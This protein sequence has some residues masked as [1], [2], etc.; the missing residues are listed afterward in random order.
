VQCGFGRVGSHFWGFELQGVTPDIVVMG[1]PIGN[2]HP[3]A[4]VVTTRDL[5]RRFANGMEYFN[6]FGGNP[7]SMAVGHAVLDVIER[8]GLQARALETG[9]LLLERFSDM[10]GRFPI[11]GDVR[12]AGLFTGV[13]LVRDR[14]TLEPATEEAGL[15]INHMRQLGVLASTDGP[16]DNVLKFKPPMVFGKAEADRLC[17]AV[18]TSLAALSSGRLK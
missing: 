10:Q 17:A 7:V 2:G 9:R 16:L 4:C 1:K 14:A 15:V 12:G 3:L 11:I 8:E 13:E 5:A 6:S 18:E